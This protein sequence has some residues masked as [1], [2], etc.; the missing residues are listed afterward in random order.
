MSE[1]DRKSALK[2]IRKNIDQYGHHIYIVQGKSALPRFAYSIGLT[3]RIGV[4]LILAGASMYYADDVTGLINAIAQSL[5]GQS[6]LSAFAVNSL[7]SFTLRAVDS[8]WANELM[9]GAVDFYGKSVSALQIVPDHDHWTLDIPNLENVWSATA[10]PVWQWLHAPWNF[11]IPSKSVATT[12]LGALR[13]ERVTEAARWEEEQWEL[14]AGA[15]PDVPQD[16]IRVVPLGTLLGIDVSVEAVTLL[17]IGQAL[18]RDAPGGDWNR[19]G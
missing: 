12:N 15:G 4:E 9:L 11:S 13:G 19:W 1:L 7:G 18:W 16:E 5:Q 10:E 3:E 2:L 8:S 17:R 14:F 6:N